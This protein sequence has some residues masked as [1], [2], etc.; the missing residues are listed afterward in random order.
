MLRVLTL[1]TLFPDVN[2]PVLGTFVERQTLGLAAHPDVELQIVVPR[3]VPPGPL[4]RHS[5][6]RD[7]AALPDYE[8]WQ[9]VPL[10]RPRFPH[11]PV[12]GARFD[13]ANIAQALIPLLTRLRATFAFDVIDAQYFFPDGPAAVALGAH[14]NVPVSIKAR[15]SD[16]HLW[17][18]RKDTRA[19]VLRAGR[20]ADGLLA[21]SAA[22]KRDMVALGMPEARIMVHYT[23]VDLALFE[24]RDRAAAKAELGVTGPLIVSVAALVPRKSQAL[25]INALP[26][27]QDAKLALVGTG[28]DEVMLRA[29]TAELG[30][31][32]RVRFLG[33]QTRAQTAHWLAAADVMALPSS[34]EGLANAWVE[35]LACGTPVVSSDVGGVRELLTNDT[36]GRLVARTSQAIAEGINVVLADPPAR[37]AVRDSVKAFTWEANTAALYEHLAV[38]VA[39]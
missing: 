11:W 2:R 6:Y 16:I 30:V 39:R 14:F 22:L 1:A 12:F 10:H 24:L 19:Q 18:M 15:G 37:I 23:G 7:S 21:V 27:V 28:P 3:G 35:A 26:S 25:V 34:S 13:A 20:L 36:A 38:L 17:G 5:A 33:R 32:D 9:G 31:A 8:L 4:A 29:L